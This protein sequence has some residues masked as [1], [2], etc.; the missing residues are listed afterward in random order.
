[1]DWGGLFRNGSSDG[2]ARRDPDCHSEGNR[3]DW[4]V[5]RDDPAGRGS[6]DG[7]TR[8]G[9]ACPTVWTVRWTRG[10]WA[11][12][13]RW[14]GKVRQGRVC[15]VGRLGMVRQQGKAGN[16]PSIGEVRGRLACHAGSVRIGVASR[17]GWVRSGLSVGLARL[18][19][20]VRL[21]PEWD[22]LSNGLGR[23]GKLAGR[24]MWWDGLSKGLGRVG[25]S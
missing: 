5:S 1:M 16:E 22:G 6:S 21:G 13:V 20:S 2:S 19:Q 15:Q 11:R 9:E 14:A 18:G 25:L 12:L 24:G 8:D 17:A 10:G 4:L 7:L 23:F 3:R